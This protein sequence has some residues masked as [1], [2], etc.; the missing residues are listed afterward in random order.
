MSMAQIALGLD[1][2]GAVLLYLTLK[3]TSI[4]L[5]VKWLVALI[6]AV[7]ITSNVMVATLV[8]A[9]PPSWLPVVWLLYIIP[10]G[11]A[12]YACTWPDKLKT[13]SY[14]SPRL[15]YW[16]TSAAA[17]FAIGAVIMKSFNKPYGEWDAWAIWNLKASF[18]YSGINDGTWS[19][20]FSQ[21][22]EWSH[23]DYPL[24]LPTTISRYWLLLGE[25]TPL[26]PVSICVLVLG[27]SLLLLHAAIKMQR[28]VSVANVSII[29]L[30]SAT[31]FIQQAGTQ[32]ADNLFA[33]IVLIAFILFR[34]LLVG[35]Y[36]SESS[37]G[38]SF[39]L[40]IVLGIA[41]SLKNEGLLVATVFFLV[42]L[43]YLLLK[44]KYNLLTSLKSVFVVSSGWLLMF[45]PTAF[46][47]YRFDVSNDV[48]S[49]FSA[50]QVPQYLSWDRTQ[51]L[52]HA[53]APLILDFFLLPIIVAC[54]ALLSGRFKLV[55]NPSSVLV[56]V[57][58]LLILCMYICVFLITPYNIEAHV[59]SA[60]Q[61]LLIHIWLV[62]VLGFGLSMYQQ[63][64]VRQ[65]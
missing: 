64:E 56:F 39:L 50:D 9:R 35:N 2:V 14:K 45:I 57:T 3:R 27:S 43:F 26:V 58:A 65:N 25:P 28:N 23:P 46:M 33:L 47:K 17:V 24:L 20:L 29:V 53:S 32:Y 12:S 42:Y 37:W 18:L 13:E 49:T 8:F 5:T 41:C 38:I 55:L 6:L 51:A 44:R 54:A 16:A 61:R 63:N 1:A 10:I 52:L 31:F 11:L 36:Q 60:L 4:A 48:I 19:R 7:A 59:N 15:F 30:L 22:I 34:Q 21:E 62:L 40:G